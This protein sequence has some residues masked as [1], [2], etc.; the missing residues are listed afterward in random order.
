MIVGFTISDEDIRT[1][2]ESHNVFFSDEKIEEIMAGI[3]DNE[4]Q[5]AAFSVDYN[6]EEDDC[7]I[8]DKQT[9]AAYDEIAKQL[10]ELEYLTKEDI[11]QYG[12]PVILNAV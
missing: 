7:D 5:E 3:D 4:V 10:Y 8:L 11:L 2:L 9:E 6:E 12:N 1:V